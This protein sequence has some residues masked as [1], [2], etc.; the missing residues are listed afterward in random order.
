VEGAEKVGPYRLEGRIGA[1]DF[2]QKSVRWE[3]RRDSKRFWIRI[4][5]ESEAGPDEESLA[6]DGSRWYSLTSRADG[7][8][9]RIDHIDPASQTELVAEPNFGDQTAPGPPKLQE[10][11]REDPWLRFETGDGLRIKYYDLPYILAI[12]PVDHSGR[13]VLETFEIHRDRLLAER[14]GD[15]VVLKFDNK[16][17]DGLL[18]VPQRVALTRMGDVHVP[19]QWVRSPEED[20]TTTT[21][22]DY[23]PVGG[24]LYPT[25]ITESLA[26][27]NREYRREYELSVKGTWFGENDFQIEIPAQTNLAVD[28]KRLENVPEAPARGFPWAG[29]FGGAVG[30]IVGAAWLRS[31]RRAG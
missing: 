4:W 24:A 7:H 30:G 23:R 19:H 9:G 15:V 20:P 28:G 10:V 22:H 2:P 16:G 5:S 6:F 12:R 27:G 26:F 17:L 1:T 14:E 31:R 29:A 11:P 21:F 13:S 25:R 18:Y 8:F 3:S